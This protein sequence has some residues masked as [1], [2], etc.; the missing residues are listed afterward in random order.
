MQTSMFVGTCLHC[1]FTKACH[2]HTT[3]TEWGSKASVDPQL[4]AEKI[5]GI[6]IEKAHF[7][8]YILYKC[9]V[10]SSSSCSH[11]KTDCTFS[12]RHCT[13]INEKQLCVFYLGIAHISNALTGQDGYIC[14]DICVPLQNAVA[15]W[16]HLCWFCKVELYHLYR[17]CKIL[18]LSYK[19]SK[20]ISNQLIL[21]MSHPTE[22]LLFTH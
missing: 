9:C 13:D 18:R 22:F 6:V 5:K 11:I 21:R 16:V 20:N 10:I 15:D 7:E 8:G 19:S 4:L 12:K 3:S 17:D 14:I 2:L 1:W